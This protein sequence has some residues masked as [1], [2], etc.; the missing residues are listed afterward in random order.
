[1]KLKL[2]F[3]GRKKKIGGVGNEVMDRWDLQEVLEEAFNCLYILD[4]E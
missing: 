4:F 2:R 3:R 1:M